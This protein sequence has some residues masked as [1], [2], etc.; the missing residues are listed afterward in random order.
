MLDLK[1]GDGQ[2]FKLKIP[3]MKLYADEE[4]MARFSVRQRKGTLSVPKSAV[5]ATF[6]FPIKMVQ[7][8]K[9]PLPE[10][11][12]E[13][14]KM[15]PDT[16]SGHR[17]LVTNSHILAWFDLDNAELESLQVGGQEL[18]AEPPM[19][20][21]WRPPT[22]NDRVDHR[23]ERVW[24]NLNPDNVVRRVLAADYR[25]I[26]SFTVGIDAMIR[27]TDKAG[28]ILF[29][30]QQTWAVLHSGDIIV[31][32]EVTPSESVKGI[33]RMGYQLALA[34]ALD[35]VRWFSLDKETYIDRKQSGVTGTYKAHANDL[36]FCYGRPQA[37]GNRAE[38]RWVSV[39]NSRAGLFVDMLDTLFCF[40]TYPYSDK[41]LATAST[42]QELQL[43]N[44]HVLNI[45]YRQAGVGS[46]LA[47]IELDSKGVVPVT[48]YVFDLHLRP[49]QLE[50]SAPEDFRRVLYPKVES[51]VL[52]MPVIEH[53]RDRFDAPMVITLSTATPQAEIHY[54]LDGSEPT[55]ESPV[56]SAPFTVSSSCI[57][58]AKSFM[59]GMTASFSA[60]KRFNFD[61]I[62]S[63]TFAYKANTPYNYAQDG[64]LFDGETGDVTDLSR[65]WLG[66]SGTDLSVVFELSKS[67]DLQDV[68]MN[69]AHVPDAWAFA[70]TSVMVSVSS[71]GTNYSAP[72]N[73]V[74]QYNPSS[75]EMSTPQLQAV[76]VIVDRPNVKYVKV[77]AKN[78]GRIPD[79]HKAKGLRP[80]LMV[81]EIHLNE[82]IK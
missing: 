76:R 43:K 32:S 24:H 79:W 42:C 14:L 21:F 73:A 4:L 74:I 30:L 68:E 82:T 3:Q 20:N 37:A 38:V 81:D 53:G 12:R 63:A 23:G 45:D 70:P 47:G 16:S 7:V 5:L 54:T 31:H 27:Y 61:Y 33:P 22:D 8:A 77:V 18:I 69:F 41:Q 6:E 35:T 26:D 66:F 40:S 49:Y 2:N 55:L 57:L 64:I 56:Y 51:S 28:E 10:Y 48:K 52:P 36:F 13:V 1:P 50:E 25:S 62:S 75:Q 19:L 65:G 29:D 80:W 60:V 11:G 15:E 58:Q 46:A 59:E 71:D 67:I 9:Q 39:S 17:L 78:M 72:F 34:R 44:C